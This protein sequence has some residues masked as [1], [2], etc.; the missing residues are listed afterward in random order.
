VEVKGEE[1]SEK[2]E[3]KDTIAKIVEVGW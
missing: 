1:K 2:P 3:Q